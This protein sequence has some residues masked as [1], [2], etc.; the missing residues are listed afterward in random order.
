MDDFAGR[1][2]NDDLIQFLIE[3]CA[4]VKARA[5]DEET[6]LHFCFNSYKLPNNAMQLAHF[7]IENGADVN[8]KLKDGRTPLHCHLGNFSRGGIINIDFLNL[9]I[10]NGADVNAKTNNGLAPLDYLL[11]SNPTVIPEGIADLLI[12][13]G[14]LIN[15]DKFL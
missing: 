15:S 3:K 6:S 2:I 4:N 12:K 1:D 10:A 9:L 11:E 8:A 5:A 7:L 14:A 13:N